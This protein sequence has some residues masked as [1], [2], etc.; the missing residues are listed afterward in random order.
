MSKKN[1]LSSSELGALWLTY[2]EK[3]LILRVLEHFLDKAEDQEAQNIMGG[4]RQELHHFIQNV[5]AIF[6]DEQVVLPVAFTKED[7]NLEAPR[8][9]EPGFDVMFVRI[10][11]EISF[12]M[13][14]FNMNM[15]YREDVITL[16]EGLTSIS[17]RNYGLATD[18]LVRRGILTLPPNHSK[19]G[20]TT[21]VKSTSYLNGLNPFA[22]KRPLNDVEIGS[23]YHEIEISHVI[24]TLFSGFAQVAGR[25][26]I[27]DYFVR[28]MNL[29]Q[30]RI[31]LF[32]NI[33][34]EQGLQFSITPGSTLTSTTVAPFSNKLMLFLTLLINGFNLV[35]TSF[36][37]LFTLRNDLSSE[38]SFFGNEIYT[39]GNDGIKLMIR[40]HLI[41]EPP[42]ME[43]RTTLISKNR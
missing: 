11:K 20:S 42:Q 28:G 43:N 1:P 34:H 40:H 37:T 17:Q 27:R 14:S 8:L 24:K 7:V 4:L 3:T 2:Q 22:E 18:Y 30:K 23:L 35:C 39:F 21:F 38:M 32:E 9:F 15:S 19:S 13:Y 5:I 36:G 31:D 33:L 16:F 29:T 12:G 41:E 25:E 6:K 26:E 10:L